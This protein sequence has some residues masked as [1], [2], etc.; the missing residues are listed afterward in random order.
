MWEQEGFDEI[1]NAISTTSG[2]VNIAL[3]GGQTPIPIYNR[4]GNLLRALPQS[5]SKSISFFVVDERNVALDSPRS[6]SGMLIKTIGAKFVVPFDP[7]KES[8]NQYFSQMSRVLNGSDQFDLV[9][10]GCGEDGHIA[11]L[12]PNTPLLQEKSAAFLSNV[13]SSGELRY[14]M[15]IPLIKQA[16]RRVILV[17]RH[18]EKL[19]YFEQ[20][21]GSRPV[22]QI[23]AIPHTKAILHEEI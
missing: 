1:A 19:R 8:P 12:F 15:T 20:E 2:K 4:I 10:L 16:R 13:L 9:V 23:L 17:N 18:T 3:S 6:N 14:S 22:H 21:E 5:K 11:S 7:T